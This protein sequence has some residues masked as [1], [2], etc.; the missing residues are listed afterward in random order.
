MANTI[1][2]LVLFICIAILL[3]SF[4]ETFIF[5]YSNLGLFIKAV[6]FKVVKEKK[7]LTCKYGPEQDVS[8]LF[9]EE[10]KQLFLTHILQTAR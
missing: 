10:C 8:G 3:Y 6:C 4:D 9:E 1:E 5:P 2:P 7:C